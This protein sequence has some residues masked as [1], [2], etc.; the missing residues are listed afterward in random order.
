MSNPTAPDPAKLVIGMFTRDKTLFAPVASELVERFGMT[1]TVSAWMDFDYT[2]YY[3][4][5]MGSPLFRRMMSFEALIGQDDLADIKLWTND[6]EKRHSASENRI[7]NIDPGYMLPS[8]FI[9][10]TG[11]D[12]AHRV[13]IGNGIYA[14]LTLMYKNGSF[15]TLP[16]TYPDYADKNM[17]FY[18][19]NVRD[20]YALDVKKRTTE[21]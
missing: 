13:Y 18:L 16:W 15:V 19:K 9:L 12:Y 8:R 10:A 7:V 1:D 5:E 3:A 21:P 2:G 14:D 6:L 4:R 11:K 20:R 17:I